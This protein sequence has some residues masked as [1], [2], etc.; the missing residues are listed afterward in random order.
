M[1]LG[2]FLCPAELAHD[3]L[4]VPMVK[5]QGSPRCPQ[6]GVR[7]PSE[8]G[9]IPVTYAVAGALVSSTDTGCS[10]AVKLNGNQQ[11]KAHPGLSSAFSTV[12]SPFSALLC[13]L[14]SHGGQCVTLK[15][16]KFWLQM[17][18]LELLHSKPRLCP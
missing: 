16:M 10:L 14:G 5:E 8:W 11:S 4:L 12:Q 17:G 15:R 1:A 13:F 7:I 9:P 3:L 18:T 2:W 6:T